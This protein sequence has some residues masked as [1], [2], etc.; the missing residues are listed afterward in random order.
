[1]ESVGRS[2]TPA[3]GCTSTGRRCERKRREVFDGE[4]INDVTSRIVAPSNSFGNWALT[5][6]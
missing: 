2:V 1:M 6:N 3:T 4:L 5:V